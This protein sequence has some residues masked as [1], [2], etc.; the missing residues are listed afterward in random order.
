MDRSDEG[1]VLAVLDGAQ[2]LVRES[3]GT[4]EPL[5]V[6]AAE[7]A[8]VEVASSPHA[9]YRDRLQLARLRRRQGRCAEAE[10]LL[11][12][13]ACNVE[14]RGGGLPGHVLRTAF[15]SGWL[16]VHDELVDLLLDRAEPGDVEA[17]RATSEQARARTLVELAGAQARCDP[18]D[19]SSGPAAVTVTPSGEQHRR[20]RGATVAY[21][22]LGRD[23]VAFVTRDDD[24]AAQRL[25][26]IVPELD[27]AL[28]SLADQW[29]RFTMG[30]EFPRRHQKALLATT[31]DVLGTLDSLVLRPLMP[32]LEG[33][34]GSDLLVVPHGRLQQIPFHALHDGREHR[35][36]Q[37]SITVGPTTAGGQVPRSRPLD[38]TSAALV[39]AVPDEHA[40]SVGREAAVLAGLLP[41]ATVLVGGAAT[42]AALEVREPGPGLLH[43]ACHGLHRS[44]DPLFSAL[45]LGDG[46]L[47]AADVL[48]LDLGGALVTLSACESGRTGGGAEP[49]GLAWA[50]LAAGASG[51]LV[52]QWLV[53]DEVTAELM[54]HYSRLVVAG[55]PPAWAL[56]AAQLAAATKYPHPYYWAAFSLAASPA[57]LARDTR[58]H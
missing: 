58:P 41:S 43:I 20:R 18:G 26:G 25:P 31:L 57:A 52:S 34:Q 19:A 5:A 3:P 11:R 16:D 37:W 40:P 42:R 48:G 32:L 23:L 30:A 56:R 9:R 6:I 53:H 28:A 24:V 46:W 8:D 29:S 22:L 17:A 10:A 21:H 15:R 27:A 12:E 49:V 33:T 36:E 55:H 47:T 39:L 14:Q 45:R 35:L 50:F 2:D 7:V 1:G 4:A 51:V 44:R 54:T 38:P 13:V